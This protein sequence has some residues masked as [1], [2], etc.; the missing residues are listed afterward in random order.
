MKRNT[1]LIH[2]KAGTGPRRT[3]NPPVEKASTV[4]LPDRKALYGE[5]PGYGRMGLSVHRELETALC[6]LENANAARLTPSGLSA[7]AVAIAAI[8]QS[9]DRVLIS[10]SLYGPTR[11]FCE[12]RLKRMGV[13]CERFDPRDVGAFENKL[14]AGVAAVF[15][16]APGSL[17]FEICDIKRLAQLS[18]AAGARTVMDNTWSAGVFCQPLDLGVDVSVQ[19]LTKY[20]VG[21][22]DAFGGAVMTKDAKIGAEIED[23]TEDWG[24]ALGPDDAYSALR[25]TRTLE[26]RL[27]QHEKAAIEVGDWLQSQPLANAIIHPALP[28]HPDHSLWC[29]DFSGSSG[30]FSFVLDA[31]TN[32]EVDAVLDALELFKLG[33]SWGG[34]ES[35]AIPCDE[36][37]TRMKTDWTTRKS[38]HLIRLH[39]GLENTSDLIDDLSRAFDACMAEKNS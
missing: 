13:S 1:R 20:I 29:R 6:T 22:S 33:F 37:L 31:Q 26:T 34:F 28:S 3:V 35:L 27:A 36:Q 15:L 18:K 11:R 30:L 12:R 14:S 10:D 17:T 5:K 8:V 23:L 2:N 32:R 25:G 4:I 21:H 16:E 19:A 7:C 38:G 24:I 9:G 39:I